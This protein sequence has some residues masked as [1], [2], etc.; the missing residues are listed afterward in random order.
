MSAKI[1]SVFIA[2]GI[3]IAL[4]VI[5]HYT[6]ASMPPY[7]NEMREVIY[8]FHMP[9]FFMLAGYLYGFSP[10]S[11]SAYGKFLKKKSKRLLIPF[12][13]ISVSFFVVK[14]VA[15]NFFKLQFPVT[16]NSFLFIFISPLDSFLPLLWFIYTLFLILIIYPFL[17]FLIKDNT[18]ILLISVLLL[19]FI[20]YRTRDLCLVQFFHNLPAF[21]YGFILARKKINF[22][23]I[24]PKLLW[25]ILIIAIAT[26]ATIYYLKNISS[27]SN[28]QLA[29]DL[30][31]YIFGS[32]ACISLSILIYHSNIGIDR[33][34]KIIGIYS[35]SIY[36]LHTMFA[37]MVRIVCYQVL[38]IPTSQFLYGALLAVSLGILLPLLIEKYIL[39]RFLITKRLFL[40]L[41]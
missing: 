15:D 33:Y 11:L 26:F 27:N 16:L 24:N 17:C 13:S 10:P 22:D 29:I 30:L 34:L 20:G 23:K 35:M 4:V 5:G 21:T 8:A 14:A 38:Q 31:L 41:G 36:L 19:Y 32:F 2:K 7:W 1:D 37:S 28:I 40:G 6:P 25:N 3:A 39:R 9:L 18:I 12:M